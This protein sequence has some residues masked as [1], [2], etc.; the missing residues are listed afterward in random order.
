MLEN[1]NIYSG[2]YTVDQA[3]NFKRCI[4]PVI[5]EKALEPPQVTLFQS[6]YQ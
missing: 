1:S 6:I 4:R 5:N 3:A 2:S